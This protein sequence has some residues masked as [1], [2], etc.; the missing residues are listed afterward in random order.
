MSARFVYL[1]FSFH[2]AGV[3]TTQPYILH[4]TGGGDNFR[5]ISVP[6][7]IVRTSVSEDLCSEV[8]GR[9]RVLNITFGKL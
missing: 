6:L 9:V 3:A 1:N 7:S 8:F 5:F 4:A 2:N